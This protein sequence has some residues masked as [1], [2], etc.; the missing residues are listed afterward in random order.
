MSAF[1]TLTT[2]TSNA[3]TLAN[4]GAPVQFMFILNMDVAPLILSFKDSLGNLLGKMSLSAAVAQD[5]PGG[6]LDSNNFPLFFSCAT[7]DLASTV[8]AA[9]LGCGSSGTKPGV[10]SQS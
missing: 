3:A 6:Y 9:H 10:G 4:P 8:S 5:A 1:G 2:L 7:I